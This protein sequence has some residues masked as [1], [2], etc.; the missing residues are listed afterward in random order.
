MMNDVE[1]LARQFFQQRNWPKI[2][3]TCRASGY[4]Q[5]LSK[6]VDF[7]A[8]VAL[9]H[10]GEIDQAQALFTGILG[11]DATNHEAGIFLARCHLSKLENHLAYRLAVA[12][13][14]G[15]SDPYYL[16]MAATILSHVG[17]PELALPLLESARKLDPVSANALSNEATCHLHL[18]NLD[19]ARNL[20]HELLTREPDNQRAYWQMAKITRAKD[21]SLIDAM[22]E[23]IQKRKLTEAHAI[24]FNFA[25]G[26]QYEDLGKWEQSFSH[27]SLAAGAVREHLNYNVEDD[28]RTIDE[29]IAQSAKEELGAPPPTALSTPGTPEPLFITGLPRSG[30][31]LVDQIVTAHSQVRSA[32]EL[33]AV[34]YAIRKTAGT[35]PL[36][37]ISANEFSEALAKRDKFRD[38]YNE[39]TEFLRGQEP[40][41]VDKMPHNYL[42]LG[43]LAKAFPHAKLVLVRRSPLAS[44]FAMYK[45]LFASKYQFSYSLQDLGKYYQAYSRLIDHWREKLGS[46]LVEVCYEDLVSTPEPQIRALLENLGLPFEAECL[47]PQEQKRN[48]MTASSHQVREKIYTSSIDRHENFSHQ[49]STLKEFFKQHRIN[50]Q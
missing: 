43:L 46:R 36:A 22:K 6:E 31:S 7:Y 2:L 42:Y 41:L 27:Y 47:R 19:R 4:R 10:L 5:G 24:F 23:N 3:E 50:T 9:F 1:Q 40:W 28:I 38:S 30:T 44:C 16:D 29:I 48:V 25:I 32:G 17:M 13:S 20:F 39:A 8:G 18:G 26:K 45:Q 11:V 37:P 12:H 49:L 34:E 15:V 21:E 14:H 33:Q 35:H